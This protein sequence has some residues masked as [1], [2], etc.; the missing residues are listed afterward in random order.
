MSGIQKSLSLLVLILFCLLVGCKN[1]DCTK[2]CQTKVQTKKMFTNNSI[3]ELKPTSV[4]TALASFFDTGTITKFYGLQM[5]SATS[6]RAFFSV[7]WNGKT[8]KSNADVVYLV[9]KGWYLRKAQYGYGLGAQ[10]WDNIMNIV[11]PNKQKSIPSKT[12]TKTK[13][14]KSS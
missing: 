8:R 11:Q 6:A 3:Q 5:L 14:K 1:T 2:R 12:K 9:D 13:K 7:N 10:W 4:K